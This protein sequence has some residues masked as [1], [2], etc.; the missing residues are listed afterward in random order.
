MELPKASKVLVP[1]L[2][3]LDHEIYHTSRVVAEG[4]E[5]NGVTSPSILAAT[6]KELEN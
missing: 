5:F 3:I 1:E 6:V 2:I 4:V